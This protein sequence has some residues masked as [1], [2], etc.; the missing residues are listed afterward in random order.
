M[1]CPLYDDEIIPFPEIPDRIN[2]KMNEQ[3]TNIPLSP[4]L[5]L[6]FQKYFPENVKRNKFASLI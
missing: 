6:L 5:F 2:K 1:L 4:T 3:K